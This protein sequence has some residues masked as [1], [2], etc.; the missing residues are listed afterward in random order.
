MSEEL[1]AWDYEGQSSLT[2]F[3]VWHGVY[4]K[5]SPTHPYDPSDLYRIA[6]MMKA[7]GIDT[8]EKRE[9]LIQRA[10]RIYPELYGPMVGKVNQWLALL[11]EELAI[12]K[13]APRL[14]EEMNHTWRH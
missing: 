4:L 7:I 11:F 5:P 2:L 14:Y 6:C 3:A 9:E 1:D 8:P 12:G 13:D 10:A